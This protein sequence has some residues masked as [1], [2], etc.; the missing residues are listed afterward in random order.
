MHTRV[1]GTGLTKLAMRPLNP[2]AGKI[3]LRALLFGCSPSLGRA[4]SA[5]PSLEAAAESLFS[6]LSPTG[7]NRLREPD[8]DKIP[9]DRDTR[10]S[11][12]PAVPP[13]SL[14]AGRRF[15]MR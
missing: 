15:R 4:L 3:P 6:I 10:T 9:R 1:A 14:G 13:R 8:K 7:G 2:L 11:D 12:M 5:N